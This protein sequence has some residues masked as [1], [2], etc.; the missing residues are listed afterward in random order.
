M[1]ADIKDYRDR[2]EV[3]SLNIIGSYSL[4]AGKSTDDECYLCRQNLLAPSFEDLQNGNLKVLVSL[5]ECGHA[6]HKTCIDIHYAK[7]NYSCPIDKT[8]WNLLKIITH[9]DYISK[10]REESDVDRN[11][12]L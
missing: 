4:K 12:L 9:T 1:T 8:P 5:G 7:N 2:I 3:E 10:K 11:K 6:F